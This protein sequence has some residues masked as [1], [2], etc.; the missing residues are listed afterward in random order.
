MSKVFNYMVLTVGLIFL[1]NFAG[2]PTGADVF[3]D[4]MGLLNG[5]EGFSLSNFFDSL[6]EIFTISGIITGIV[7]GFLVRSSPES[8]I[9]SPLATTLLTTLSMTFVSIVKYTSN[10]GYVYYLTFMIFIPLIAG[11]GI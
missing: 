1:L 10:F 9:I 6:E 7:I 5:A 8:A 11:F 4:W 3:I 2:L